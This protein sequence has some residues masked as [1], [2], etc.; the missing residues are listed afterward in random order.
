MTLHLSLFRHICHVKNSNLFKHVPFL[1]WIRAISHPN[2]HTLPE[3][4]LS[5]FHLRLYPLRVG[6]LFNALSLDQLL[7]LTLIHSFHVFQ[8]FVMPVQHLWRILTQINK[9]III[10]KHHKLKIF[11]YQTSE[12]NNNKKYKL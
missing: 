4:H 11:N 7:F 2:P 8:L 10:T 3:H 6:P 5:R 1:L 9:E 12:C